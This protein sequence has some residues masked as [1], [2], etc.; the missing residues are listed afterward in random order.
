M[1]SLNAEKYKE[2]GLEQVYLKAVYEMLSSMRGNKTIQ[3]TKRPK[4]V[5]EMVRCLMKYGLPEVLG[6]EIPA[7]KDADDLD[8]ETLFGVM[9]ALILA[10]E[11]KL[12]ELY[13]RLQKKNPTYLE[14][15]KQA[16]K[17]LNAKKRTDEEPK[18]DKSTPESD[19]LGMFAFLN[20]FGERAYENM[21][22]IEA[23]LTDGEDEPEKLPNQMVKSLG[24][25][26]CPYCNRAFI[27]TEEKENLG[28]QLD[29]FYSKSI[30]PFFAVSLYNLIPCCSYCNRIKGNRDAATLVSP[31]KKDADFENGL[32]FRLV[33]D[34]KVRLYVEKP[35]S[36]LTSN[37][38][39]FKLDAAYA[40]HKTEAK[41]FTDKMRAYPPSLLREIARHMTIQDGKTGEKIER[42]PAE[43]LE[44][45]LFQEYF[46]EPADYLKKPL[47]KFYRDLYYEYR[48]TK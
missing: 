16:D 2:S 12:R 47:A 25:R 15:K 8:E 40:F 18:N 27:G 42:I 31:F 6:A 41:Q 44:M 38:N 23:S 20:Y 26:T 35:D 19:L 46:C 22:D 1:I 43:V 45:G 28:V 36:K 48:G 34:G 39:T 13:E 30:Y 17:K 5:R 32:R 33:E 14:D 3:S 11:K 29:H 7:G 37:I 24:L 21:R 10:D 9:K 4:V